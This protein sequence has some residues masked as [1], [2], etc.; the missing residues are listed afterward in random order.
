MWVVEVERLRRSDIYQS[1][2]HN[3]LLIEGTNQKWSK[4]GEQ[5]MKYATTACLCAI[6]LEQLLGAL[7]MCLQRSRTTWHHELYHVNV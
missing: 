2:E 3:L 6:R 4:A 7:E 5:C 1:T